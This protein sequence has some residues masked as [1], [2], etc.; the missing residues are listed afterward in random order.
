M[1]LGAQGQPS[2]GPYNSPLDEAYYYYGMRNP[3]DPSLT[4]PGHSFSITS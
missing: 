2:L 1:A 4:A 3:L